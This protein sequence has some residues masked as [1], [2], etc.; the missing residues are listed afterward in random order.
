MKKFK[1]AVAVFISVIMVMTILAACGGNS[2]SSD[3]GKHLRDLTGAS[4]STTLNSVAS[5]LANNLTVENAKA[6]VSG[7]GTILDG[8]AVNS[9]VLVITYNKNSL[10]TGISRGDS[11]IIGTTYASNEAEL[12]KVVQSYDNKSL[13]AAAMK[14]ACKDEY[15]YDFDVYLA[16]REIGNNHYLYVI[17]YSITGAMSSSVDFYYAVNYTRG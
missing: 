3:I 7:Y 4:E 8:Y 6:A 14:K 9:D 17:D 1:R 11:F 13:N 10:G 2:G 15:G 5:V 12:L 16:I